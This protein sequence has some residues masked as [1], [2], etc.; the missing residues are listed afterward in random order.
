[1]ILLATG[2]FS[3][4]SVAAAGQ[5]CAVS[6]IAQG[7]VVG[8]GQTAAVRP[9]NTTNLN[10]MFA[11]IGS[12]S[13]PCHNVQFPEGTI[14]INGA[15]SVSLGPIT[16]SGVNREL[17]II[18][19]TAAA[20]PV[21]L[22]NSNNKYTTGISV[23]DLGFDNANTTAPYNSS[24]WGLQLQCTANGRGGNGWGYANNQVQRLSI[25]HG[26]AAAAASNAVVGAKTDAAGQ[27]FCQ[28]SEPRR[29]CV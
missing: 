15:I 6:V 3:L 17:S 24:Q 13:I 12:G 28:Q 4:M 5:T 26:G 9:A 27:D 7:V 1:M 25:S 11:S 29:N 16:I 19:Q 23:H 22:W 18:M 20:A 8:S 10:N 2:L 21:F 14:E